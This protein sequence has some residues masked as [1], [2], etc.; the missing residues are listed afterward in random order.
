MVTNG[1]TGRDHGGSGCV[2]AF[3]VQ[4]VAVQFRDRTTPTARHADPAGV[5]AEDIRGKAFGCGVTAADRR[6]RASGYGVTSGDR[7]NKACGYRASTGY[8][9][10]PTVQFCAIV[11]RIGVCTDMRTE[12]GNGETGGVGG[13]KDAFTEDIDDS[14]PLALPTVRVIVRHIGVCTD[15]ITVGVN[16]ETGGVGDDEATA[17]GD[18]SGK[19]YP[20]LQESSSYGST[21]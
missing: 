19:P 14:V 21:A 9:K 15:M 11:R 7:W 12:E 5:T 3:R 20:E 1:S 2:G 8:S 18:N 13:S 17:E 6:N 16:G 10:L 4:R